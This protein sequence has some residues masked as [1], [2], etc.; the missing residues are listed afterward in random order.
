MP[1]FISD[2]GKVAICKATGYYKYVNK[3][4]IRKWCFQCRKHLLH[5]RKYFVDT[6][7]W[8]GPGPMRFECEKCKRDNTNFP[9]W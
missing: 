4:R 1:C 8:Y 7:S 6:T 2:D 5:K 9:G 3:R